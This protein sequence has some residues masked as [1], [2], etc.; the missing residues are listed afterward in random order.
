MHRAWIEVD[1]GAIR[2]NLK[3]LSKWA[4]PARFLSVVKSDAYGHGME[5][6]ARIAVEEGAWG[7]AVVNID[8][9]LRLRAAGFTCPVVIVGPIFAFELKAALEANLSL[10]VYSRE[11]LQEVT[12]AARAASVTARVHVKF[13]TGLGRLALPYDQA[14]EF[15]SQVRDT[16]ELRVEGL[17]SHLADAEGLDQ[18]YTLQQFT[19]FQ[20]VQQTA[21]ELGIQPEICHLSASAASMLIQPARLDAVRLGIAMYGLWPAEE[22]RLLLLSRGHNLFQELNQHFQSG[23]TQELDDLLRPALAYKTRIAQL[24][25]VPADSSIGYGCTYVTQRPTTL[26]VLPIGYYEGYDRHLSNCGEVLI[27]GR[28]ARVLGRVCMNVVTVDVT[29]IAGVS[30]DDEVVLLGRQGSNQISAEEWAR[31]IGTINYEVVTRLPAH[32][33]RIYPS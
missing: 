30:L 9:G 17:Y 2:H 26:A 16:P 20:E 7:L 25:Q 12:E 32:L 15:L 22:T 21:A 31:R 19:R 10:P 27:R 28:R 14:H 3:R 24:K 8:E 18:R 33:P 23:L 4:A 29:D 1:L 13:D 11:V 5:A 6:V